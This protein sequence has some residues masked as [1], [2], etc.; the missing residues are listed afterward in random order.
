MSRMS[1]VA[2]YPYSI[3]VTQ[4][5]GWTTLYTEEGQVKRS[6]T[7]NFSRVVVFKEK[8]DLFRVWV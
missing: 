2:Y 3:I 5:L 6:I 7:K 4:F 1:W 8:V